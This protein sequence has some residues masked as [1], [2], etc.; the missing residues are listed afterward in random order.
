[1]ALALKGSVANDSSATST[2]SK[3]RSAA[4]PCVVFLSFESTGGTGQ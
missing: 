3:S 4:V 2:G 1:M